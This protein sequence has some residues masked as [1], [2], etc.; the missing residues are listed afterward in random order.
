[1]SDDEEDYAYDLYCIRATLS[2][3]LS[4]PSTRRIIGYKIYRNGKNLVL[5]EWGADYS[6][7]LNNFTD[8]K[9]LKGRE[10]CYS[11]HTYYSDYTGHVASEGTTDC[12]TINGI[13]L[14]QDEN[15]LK[16]Y[17]NPVKRNE[18]IQIETA[19]FR[20]QKDSSLQ[21]YDASGKAV[22][23]VKTESPI[24]PVRLDVEAGTYILKINGNKA[25]KLIVE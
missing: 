17:P 25:V 18:I 12:I 22:K 7:E 20:N 6:I 9:P 19:N 16:V 8:T 10:A 15:G 1:M 21:I 23:T 5:D 14:I 24:T 3:D 2:K 4:T 13:S 11:V